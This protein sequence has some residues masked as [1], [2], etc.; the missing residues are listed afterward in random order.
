MYLTTISKV[1]LLCTFVVSISCNDGEYYWR[2]WTAGSP[3]S[4]AVTT[5]DYRGVSYI[6]EAYVPYYGLFIGQVF[7]NQ[8]RVNVSVPSSS[9]TSD[10]VIQDSRY[11]KVLCTQNLEK[12][13][14]YPT[15]YNTI[16]NELVTAVVSP[17]LGGI[18]VN[19]NLVYIGRIVDFN[20]RIVILG[21]VVEDNVLHYH[22]SGEAYTQRYYE[23]LVIGSK[24]SSD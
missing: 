15:H 5:R 7:A 18:N 11:L 10:F 12:L 20:K 2:P 17:V 9:K 13:A 1:L 19:D 22:Y 3:P 21:S 8:H 23:I 4:D 14:W 16:H 24:C 6:V